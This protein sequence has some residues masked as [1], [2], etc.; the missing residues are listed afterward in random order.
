MIVLL[1][2]ACN[3]GGTPTEAPVILTTPIATPVPALEL[4][5]SADTSAPFNAVGQTINYSYMIRNTSGQNFP[6]PLSLVDE[7]RTL[8][9]PAL[10]TVGNNDDNFDSNEVITCNG[11]YVITQ[12]D[13]DAGTVN[14]NAVASIG[15]GSSSAVSIPVAMTQNRTLTLS[16]AA[17]PEIFDSVDQVVNYTYVILN[18]GNVTLQGPFSIAD[19]KLVVTAC[20][21]PEDNLL[22]PNEEM[23]CTASY[24]IVQADL[25]A[26]LVTNTASAT[27]GETTSAEVSKTI[28]KTGTGGTLPPQGSDYQHVVVKGEWLWQ[29]ARCYGAN[30]R[31]VIN[32]NPQLGNPSEIPPGVTVTVPSVGSTGT[33]YGTPCIHT[34]TIVDGDTWNTIADKYSTY[35]ADALLIQ[36]ANRGV[37]LVPGNNVR[38]PVGPYDYP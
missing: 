1:L 34:Y 23:S 29:I 6:G 28:N 12:A 17:N 10:N 31:D 21:Q 7:N 25:D 30:P 15:G 35:N 38:V 14:N 9:C 16:K 19:N 4:T 2:S 27:N 20:T 18:G 5:V 32:T 22:S 8:E 37:G 24:T 26:G 13:L 36:E 33:I 11:T 3:L